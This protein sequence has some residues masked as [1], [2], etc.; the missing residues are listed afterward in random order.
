MSASKLGRLGKKLFGLTL[1]VGSAAAGTI[2]YA[3]V[4]PEFRHK[5]EGYVPKTKDLFKSLIGPIR[6]ETPTPKIQPTSQLTIEKT[7]TSVN[8]V[9]EF[10]PYILIGAGTASY[11]AALT[12]RAR[13]PDAI[14]L[15]LGDEDENAY[16]RSPLSKELW[17]YGD[18]KFAETL[19]YKSL[20]G[21]VRDVYFEV[22]GFYI[23]PSDWKKFPHGCI[24]ILKNARVNKISLDD[25][26]VI[27]ES[28]K[29]IRF[30]K[31]LIAT[32]S[33]PK[34]LPEFKRPDLSDR[35]HTL[36]TIKDFREINAILE[37]TKSIAIIGGGFLASE[38]AYSLRRRF[39]HV[40]DLQIF[41]VFKE[42]DVLEMA[43]P[44]KISDDA[45][46]QLFVEGVKLINKSSVFDVSRTKDQTIRLILRKD[47]GS[48]HEI[49]VD[50]IID[51]SGSQPNVEVAQKSGLEIDK[52]NG[53]IVVDSGMR[54]RS[55]I[56]AAGDV[57]SFFDLNLGRRRIEHA[58]NAEITGR[59]AGENMTNGNRAYPRQ[60]MF[61]ST[62]G[63]N[64]HI[65][66]VG[67][68]DPK[69]KTV[70]VS[71]QKAEEFDEEMRAVTF[72]I[73]DDA[74]VGV[75]LYNVFGDGILM[76]RKIIEDKASPKNATDLARLFQLYHLPK[77]ENEAADIPEN[78]SNSDKPEKS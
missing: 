24:S 9:P 53:G 57:S 48:K 5:I 6:L 12:I 44:A 18:E 52:E 26:S 31:C 71:A 61:Q 63:N 78:S 66:G 74:I 32:G 43:L 68:I 29:R 30:N 65:L 1:V 50:H 59:V 28:G 67:R 39:K 70:V 41:Q 27:L 8:D 2:G 23:K 16:S 40:K 37:K 72:Y 14:V 17:W 36:Y 21:R 34:L 45:T 7:T 77:D 64:A 15:I 13:D 73:N 49:F 75:L 25:K 20:S 10:V 51:V 42:D 55:D 60:A 35:I 11:Y 19:Q 33:R 62:V 46:K 3:Y 56:F 38:L 54:A 76:A 47:D 69:L 22:D 58:E 4:D